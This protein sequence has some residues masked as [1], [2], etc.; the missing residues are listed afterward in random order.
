MDFDSDRIAD[1][2]DNSP[3]VFFHCEVCG[4]MVKLNT[5][6]PVLVKK[7]GDCLYENKKDEAEVKEEAGSVRQHDIQ[8]ERKEPEGVQEAREHKEAPVAP[9]TCDNCGSKEIMPVFEDSD[10]TLK[11]VFYTCHQCKNCMG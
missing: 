9:D 2:R 6:Y 7:C 1:A 8:D 11:V 4:K 3:I 5:A 10:G